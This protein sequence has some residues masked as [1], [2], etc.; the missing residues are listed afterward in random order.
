[1]RPR[2]EGVARRRLVAVYHQETEDTVGRILLDLELDSD[3]EPKEPAL[4]LGV[5]AHMV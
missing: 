4:P 5:V 2:R 1:M 3:I